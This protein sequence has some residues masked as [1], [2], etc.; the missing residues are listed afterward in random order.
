M[1][2]ERSCEDVVANVVIMSVRR[3]SWQ[4]FAC[5]RRDKNEFQSRMRTLD[6]SRLTCSV[7]WACDLQNGSCFEQ[8]VYTGWNAKKTS[9]GNGSLMLCVP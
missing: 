4:F 6:I 8:A 3:L 2:W 1:G 5:E 9:G 7:T